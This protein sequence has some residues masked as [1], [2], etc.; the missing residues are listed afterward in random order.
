MAKKK[1]KP[2]NTPRGKRFKRAQRLEAAKSWLP[3][4]EGKDIVKGY[5]KRYGVDFRC[6]FTELEMLGVEIDP[7]RKEQILRDVKRQAEIRRQKKLKRATDWKAHSDGRKMITLP[8]SSATLAMARPMASLGTNART[9]GPRTISSNN[10]FFVIL[11][12][13]HNQSL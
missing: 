11:L 7:A 4:Y 12:Y 3:T 5:R 9:S 1:R 2:G 8:Y 13:L 6:A 10:P